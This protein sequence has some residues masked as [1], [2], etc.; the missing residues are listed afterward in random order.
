MSLRELLARAL[1]WIRQIVQVE[2]V[3][4]EPIEVGGRRLLPVTRAVHIG[5]AGR[6]AGSGWVWNRPVALVE[7]IGEGIYRNYPIRDMTLQTIG[8][9]LA[10]AL[11]LRVL[12]AWLFRR[13]PCR[14][15]GSKALMSHTWE[16]NDS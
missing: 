7:E 8:A 1:A 6:Q 14:V 12:L 3:R 4:G 2:Q 15:P 11:V 9:I 13:R 16:V 5:W 10:S